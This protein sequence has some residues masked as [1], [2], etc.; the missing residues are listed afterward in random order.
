MQMKEVKSD[1]K[2]ISQYIYEMSRS[3]IKVNGKIYP[4]VSIRIGQSQYIINKPTS[5]TEYHEAGGS[6]DGEVFATG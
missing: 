6:I 3:S 4:G 1:L 2:K 5:Y